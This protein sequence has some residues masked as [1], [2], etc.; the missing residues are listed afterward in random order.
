MES[1]LNIVGWIWPVKS[2]KL[3]Y[4]SE[5]PWG[6]Q[7]WYETSLHGYF[8][9]WFLFNCYIYLKI[10]KESPFSGSI[11]KYPNGQI[12]TRLKPESRNSIWFSFLSIWAINHC[13]PWR[14]LQRSWT[15][16]WSNTDP[17][18]PYM[19]CGRSKWYLDHSTKCL[20]HLF[21]IDEQVCVQC[22][23]SAMVDFRFLYFLWLYHFHIYA[24]GMS[25]WIMS[26]SA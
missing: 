25:R 3:S 7:Q 13:L 11:L 8:F 9:F 23:M 12:W 17:V 24:P 14:G 5:S 2:T 16:R 15:K 19:R 6:A 4:L 10:D 1:Q 18:L 26:S 21:C 22:D 20:P